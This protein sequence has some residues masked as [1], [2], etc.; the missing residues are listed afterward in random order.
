MNYND[1]IGRWSLTMQAN[2]ISMPFGTIEFLP[3]QKIKAPWTRQLEIPL[4]FNPSGHMSALF[5]FIVSELV[6]TG[7]LLTSFKIT[8]NMIGLEQTFVLNRL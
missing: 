5:D 1:F 7:L 3:T 8:L 6:F 2:G 4:T